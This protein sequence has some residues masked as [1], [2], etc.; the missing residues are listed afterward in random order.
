MK[1]DKTEINDTELEAVTGGTEAGE[2]SI[3]ENGLPRPDRYPKTETDIPGWSRPENDTPGWSR[4]TTD[5][6]FELDIQEPGTYE[7][8]GVTYGG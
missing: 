6:E 7:L 1:N 4:Q 3:P 5:N 2:W 8:Y